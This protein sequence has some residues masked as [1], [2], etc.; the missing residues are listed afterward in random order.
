MPS[1]KTHLKAGMLLFPVYFLV[2]NI[3]SHFVFN[4]TFKPDTV[5]LTMAYVF[6]VLGS[7][8]PDI[9]SNNAPIRWF[10]H[11]VFSGIIIGGMWNFKPVWDFFERTGELKA[12]IIVGLGTISGFLLGYSLNTLKHRGF[13]HSNLFGLGYTGFCYIIGRYVLNLRGTDLIFVSLSGFFGVFTHLLL[14]YKLKAFR[15]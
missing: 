12:S 10:A 2:F 13:L 3:V 7:D 11:A 14:D 4:Q 8:L 6:F 1:L 15:R 5:S 9:D